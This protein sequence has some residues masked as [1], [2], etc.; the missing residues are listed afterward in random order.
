M[1]TLKKDSCFKNI[2][3]GD[4][5]G[6]PV[7]KVLVAH[8]CPT[9]LQPHG[10]Y[11]SRLLCPWNSPGK[12]T[13]VGSHFLLQGIFPTQGSNPHLLYLLHCRQ[14]VCHQGS[15]VVKTLPPN[16]GG[17]GSIPGWAAKVPHA[18]RPENQ[19]MKQKH[20]RKWS[21]L[22]KSFKKFALF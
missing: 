6:G 19:N 12:N 2:C 14:I 11:P 7:V 20:Y 17:V 21:I 5:P 15:P 8:L 10:W 1:E 9:L 18:S 16:A 4:F 3:F 13:A 22:K